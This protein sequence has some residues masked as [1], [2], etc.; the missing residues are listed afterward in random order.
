MTWEQFK[1]WVGSLAKKKGSYYC[2]GHASDTWKLQTSFYREAIHQK[3]SLLDYLN[4][5][6]PEVHYQIS[7]ALNETID[8]SNDQMLAQFLSLIQHHGFPTPL[9]DWTI[10]PYIAAYFA[11]REVDEQKPLSETIRIYL[12]NYIEWRDSFPQRINLR[13]EKGEYVSIIRPYARNNPRIIAQQGVFTLTNVD[14]M[15]QY[16]L[17]V[18]EHHNKTF[19]YNEE[20]SV[21]EKPHVM[22]ELN[23]MGINEMTLFP[24]LGGICRSL[25]SQFF[26]PDTVGLTPKE[27][28]ELLNK[29]S[30]NSWLQAMVTGLGISKGA[31]PSY[32]SSFEPKAGGWGGLG[33]PKEEK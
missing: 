32:P 11:F 26:S 6:I 14:D 31:L 21:K 22:R 16:I 5:I 8:L 10:S 13:E 3:I 18:Q 29:P 25:K 7:A 4:K 23:L 9:L 17:L 33:L 12:F 27:W 30:D 20:L 2:R 19:L 15:E 28:Q 24:G 1:K